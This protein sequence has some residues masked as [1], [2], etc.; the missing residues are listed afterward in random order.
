MKNSI[1]C[2]V[3]LSFA[4]CFSYAQDKIGFEFDYAQYAYNADSN[5]IEIY[6]SFGQNSLKTIDNKINVQM[7]IVIKDSAATKDI[8]NKDF[9]LNQPVYAD[10]TGISRSLVGVVNFV[11][12]KGVYKCTVSGKDLNLPNNEKVISEIVKITPFINKNFSLSNLQLAANIV[13]ENAHKNSIFYKN[14]Y[15]VIPIPISVFGENQPIL[16][17]YYEI[18]GLLSVKQDNALKL[19]TMVYNSKNKRVYNKSKLITHKLDSQVQVGSIP[20]NKF[21][22]DTYTLIITLVDS[23]GNY[24]CTS[25]KKFFVYNPS[26]IEKEE[27]SKEVGNALTSEFGAMSDEELDDVYAK[28]KY[29]VTSQESK[30]YEKITTTQ[31]KREFL[32]KFWKDR[33]Y[34]LTTQE[35]EAFKEYLQKIEVANQKYGSM[36]K[37]GWKSDRGRIFLIYG[38]PSE[39]E[40]FPNSGDT[41][42]YEIWHYNE[43]QGGTICVFGDLSGFSDYMLIH[44]TIRGELRDDNYARRLNAM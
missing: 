11:L 5:Y 2:L 6:Y 40:R 25:S 20:V 14:S 15:E 1:I 44:S 41:K 22:N 39:V 36:Q 18:Y 10:S 8:V 26:I 7:H 42:P 4:A 43:L 21:A 13:Q 24:G 3:L 19:N 35:N 27:L 34:D 31:G 28:T 29:L 9:K 30:K 37:I 38:E 32:Y 12:P 17:F 33:D 16:F 23:A